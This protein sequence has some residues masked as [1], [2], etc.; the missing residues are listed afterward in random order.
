MEQTIKKTILHGWHVSHHANMADFGGYN[1]PLWYPWGTKKEHLQVL[2]SAGIFDTSHMAVAL[3][4]GRDA[5]ELLQQCFSKDLSACGK[6][7]GP[8]EAGR[9]VYG[10]YLDENGEAIDDAI[11]YRLDSET[12][13]TVVNAGMG[14]A[15][16]RHLM[17]HVEGRD[18]KVNDLTDQ[19]GK[20]DIQGP[21]SAKVLAKILARPDEVFRDMRY[22][23]FKG[24]F[25]R[26]SPLADGARLT[27]GTPILLSRTGYTG[28]FGFEIFVEP[29]KL[30]ELWESI[31]EAGR[32]FDLLSC[33][34]AAR[35]SLRAGAVLPLSHQ[36]IG[37]WPFINNPW[38]FALPCNADG[39]GFTKKFIG[40]EALKNIAVPE[41]TH[42]FVGN[43]PRKVSV[44]DPALVL[45]SDG[46]E[47][48]TVL[49][50][51][52]ELAI[53]RHDGRIFSVASPDKPEG[54]NPRGLCCGFVKA[55]SPLESGQTLRLKDNRREIKVMIVDDIRPNRTARYSIREML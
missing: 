25:D 35:D 42:A 28:E 21:L 24:H 11:V 46:H 6:G 23:S 15:I 5:F 20:M 48:G 31:L 27:D 13:M 43:D 33:G 19:V 26:T 47:I 14:G 12:Y 45:D 32:E 36:D 10:V 52:S 34:L 50:C 51:V 41:Y 2:A 29:G 53:D 49:S 17:N 1:M 38:T 4:S 55:R 7:K 18:V 37:H 8:L 30:P 40:G 39:T 9:C 44:S 22:F 54:F 16:A 3:I